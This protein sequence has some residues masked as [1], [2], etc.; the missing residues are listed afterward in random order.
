MVVVTNGVTDWTME[1]A[2]VKIHMDG[3]G[4]QER[5]SDQEGAA[6]F[7]FKHAKGKER[8]NIEVNAVSYDPV[9]L[10]RFIHD[11]E[12]QTEIVHVKLYPTV[13]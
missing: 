12:G 10:T 11:P 13:N 2:S 1:G 8:Y 9:D 6:F 3:H 5:F 4:T 7:T